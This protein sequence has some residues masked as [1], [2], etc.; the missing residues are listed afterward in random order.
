MARPAGIDLSPIN[1]AVCIKEDALD[2]DIEFFAE[3]GLELQTVLHECVIVISHNIV[4]SV[5]PLR[6]VGDHIV[7]AS[8][9]QLCVDHAEALFE[10]E[11]VVG[12]V[13]PDT[14]LKVAHN[15]VIEPRVA[16]PVRVLTS[17]RK[18]HVP[19]QL[20]L[21]KKTIRRPV[22]EVAVEV[23][24]IEAG[25][26]VIILAEIL[27]NHKTRIG[28]AELRFVAV[29]CVGIPAVVSVACE[30]RIKPYHTVELPSAETV[31]ED[32]YSLVDAVDLHAEG[33]ELV[34]ELHDELLEELE[35]LLGSLFSVDGNERARH[36][37]R[38]LVAGGGLGSLESPVR[39][40][41]NDA[42][43][44]EEPHRVISPVSLWN[45]HKR[46]RRRKGRSRESRHDGH[47]KNSHK[48]L[49]N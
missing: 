13:F 24:G 19:G 7:V 8:D 48:F 18:G 42:A 9:E 10:V 20:H 33:V 44:G 4:I 28:E 37:R 15:A 49:H 29:G 40:A 43:R 35:I 34:L 1:I 41:G 5:F 39:I 21:D 36:D 30:A 14:A 46:I 2:T 32:R 26:E 3:I 25:E 17:E 22:G 47:R 38:H 16:F 31:L 6:L 23:A 11:S 12:L 45:V 27:R